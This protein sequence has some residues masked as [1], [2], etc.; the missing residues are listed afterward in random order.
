MNKGRDISALAIELQRQ[1]KSAKDFIADT[2]AIEVIPNEDGGGILMKG[3]N[4]EPKGINDLAHGQIAQHLNIPKVYY[5]R[6]L[7]DDPDLLSDNVNR[8]MH[9]EPTKRM[10]RTLDN[11]VRAFLSNKFRIL[12]NFGVA[13]AALPV[14]M[15]RKAGRAD[16]V[17][18]ELTER[19]LYIKATFPDLSDEVPEGMTLGKGH[20]K[21]DVIQAGIV[22]SNSEVGA[23]AIRIEPAV[24]KL[25]CTNMLIIAQSTMKKFHIG[26]S[27]DAEAVRELLS[28]EAKH[29]DDRAVWLAVR[30]VIRKSAD[31]EFF[32]AA[33][34]Q[35]R[36]AAQLPIPVNDVPGVVEATVEQFNLSE[37]TGKSILGHLIEGGSLTQWGLTN[38][39]TRTAE[40][41]T[42]YEDST[43]LERVG[44]KLLAMPA[45]EW[46]SF[47]KAA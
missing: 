20:E 6:M 39:V 11:R 10:V 41:Q 21:I 17:S 18:A 8:W 7:H 15:E 38:A 30:D 31:P 32:Q 33:I 42:D 4:G 45:E 28:D 9:R 25:G 23:G 40:D 26:R 36:K 16:I 27:I 37:A 13:E 1:Q 34:N 35:I 12:D 44:G 2:K 43:E 47:V 19:R 46:Q 29:A 3:L 22:I 5:D 24:Y 14:L